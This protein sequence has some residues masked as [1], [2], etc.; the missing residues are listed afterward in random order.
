MAK[1]ESLHVIA[2]I[3]GGKDSFFSLL[4]CLRQGHKV[5]A[6]GNLYP[7]P[8]EEGVCHEE[9]DLNSFMYQTV[10]HTIIPLYAQALG[11]PLYRQEIVGTA[12]QTAA[13]YNGH[14]Q[15]TQDG[16]NANETG[17]EDETESLVPLLKK[18]KEKHPDANAVCTG[19]ILSTYQRTRIEA[20]CIRLGLVPLAFL[21]QFPVL[22][23][24]RE[25]QLLEDMEAVGLDARIVKVASGG[26]DEGVLWE[27]VASLRGRSRVSKSLGRLGGVG[28]GAVIGEGGE[29][30]TVVLD[31][32]RRLFRGSIVVDQKEQKVVDEGGGVAWVRIGK[33]ACVMKERGDVET[34]EDTMQAKEDELAKVRVPELLEPRFESCFQEILSKWNKLAESREVDEAA[35]ILLGSKLTDASSG[36]SLFGSVITEQPIN[37]RHY[38]TFASLPTVV[39]GATQ[40]MEDIREQIQSALSEHRLDST[41]IISAVIVLRSMADFGNINSVRYSLSHNPLIAFR[42][43]PDTCTTPY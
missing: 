1:P 16:T 31:G 41:N 40:E 21:W 33:A 23:P 22:P 14:P 9:Q 6:L 39:G 11:I 25:I 42:I 27:N 4:H 29:F 24:K 38:W 34:A 7:A 17:R 36:I 30:E 19:A 15:N 37:N 3:S 43:I 5:V 26:L 18:I 35:E 12:V 8:T 20:V 10:G 32:P 13:S 2:L 28:K